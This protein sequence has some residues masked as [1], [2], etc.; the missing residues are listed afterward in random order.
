MDSSHSL[1]FRLFLMTVWEWYPSPY[2]LLGAVC[3]TAVTIRYL[4]GGGN[5]P[6]CDIFIDDQYEVCLLHAR[7]D[8]GGRLHKQQSK[9]IITSYR[10][11]TSGTVGCWSSSHERT[12]FLV[13]RF[14]TRAW[15]SGVRS[16]Y[17]R[18][19][20]PATLQTSSH[21]ASKSSH[22]EPSCEEGR[23]MPSCLVAS[24]IAALTIVGIAYSA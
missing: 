6:C 10:K 9:S 18:M 3:C 15:S 21:S 22:Q 17:N 12:P 16:W 4:G 13:T 1:H 2:L 23:V 20:Y 14:K 8:K 7:N 19:M 24:I 11:G 5:V